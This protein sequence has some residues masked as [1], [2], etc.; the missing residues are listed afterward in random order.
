MG[1]TDANAQ[2][3]MGI[4]KKSKPLTTTRTSVN[5]IEIEITIINNRQNVNEKR[6]SITYEIIEKT[7]KNQNTTYCG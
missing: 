2:T 6:T 5:R 3:N 1:K 4:I 7:D